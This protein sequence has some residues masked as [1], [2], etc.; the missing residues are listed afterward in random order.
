MDPL[1]ERP[2][3]RLVAVM[4]RLRA[5]DGCP[6]DREQTLETLK[7]YLVE[8]CY[9]EL[10]AIDSG[11]RARILDELGD[12]LLQVVFQ[13]QICAEEGAFTFDDVAAHLCEKLVRRHPHVFGDARAPDA[14]SVLRRWDA[15]KRDERR[16]AGAE[17]APSA[18]DGVPRSMPSLARAEQVQIRAA[19][20]GFDWRRAGDVLGKLEEEIRELREAL[21]AGRSERVRD[22]AG[23]L[24][25]T[26]VN[27][28]RRLDVHAESALAASTAK[29]VRRF[30]AME[31]QLLGEGRRLSDCPLEDLDAAWERVKDDEG[32][33][34]GA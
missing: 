19:R 20:A 34:A 27:L 15:I 26:A 21:A 31:A 2:V 29:F 23:D 3:D 25:F 24:L 8:E 32:D 22:E 28:C 5:P 7:R 9:E 33:A 1:P 10:D 13:S 6:W 16:G 4:R 30:R 14:A 18:L 11:D 17:A 12:L